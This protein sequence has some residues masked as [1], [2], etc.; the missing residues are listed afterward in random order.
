MKNQLFV[1]VLLSSISAYA[2]TLTSP[3]VESTVLNVVVPSEIKVSPSLCRN[4]ERIKIQIGD[5][6]STISVLTRESEDSN[7]LIVLAKYE[8][9]SHSGKNIVRSA[10][11]D[12]EGGFFPDFNPCMLV[13]K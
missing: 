3:R 11:L 6:N 2:A 13:L 5:R 4:F 7:L 12:Y 8:V 9:P 10:E 1:F